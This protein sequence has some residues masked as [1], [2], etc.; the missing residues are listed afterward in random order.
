MQMLQQLRSHVTAATLSAR[1]R[2]PPVQ[3]GRRAGGGRKQAAAR[4]SLA[5]AE[6]LGAQHDAESQY[7]L[8]VAFY[9]C[10]QGYPRWQY[11]PVHVLATY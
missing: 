3:L 2:H 9:C 1:L 4:S 8:F 7:T 6:R 10:S 11:P 5:F